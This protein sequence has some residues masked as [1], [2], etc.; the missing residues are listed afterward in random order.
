MWH[1]RVSSAP[2]DRVMVAKIMA[3]SIIWYH[4]PLSTCWDPA[5]DT[6]E[7][8]IQ[9]FIWRD[10]PAKVAKAT[11]RGE[12]NQ[13]GLRVWDIQAK[14]KAFRSMWILKLL[15]GNLNPIL[16]AT[17]KAITE[18]YAHK[19]NTH[20]PLWES[21]VDHS[22]NINAQINSP[23]L[24]AFQQAWTT[25]V[26]RNP[27]LH[28]G[29]WV[30]YANSEEPGKSTADKVYDGR[31]LIVEVDNNQNSST[32]FDRDP[33]MGLF[34]KD[35]LEDNKYW[36]MSNKKCYKLEFPATDLSPNRITETNQKSLYIN[37]GPPRD[38]AELIKLTLEDI[39]A[40]EDEPMPGEKFGPAFL[41]KVDNSRL[42]TAQL[43]RK[44]NFYIKENKWA[45]KYN[46]NI[47]KPRNEQNRSIA[48]SR[49]KGFMW[50][51]YSHAL[52][53]KDRLHGSGS[54][55]CPLCGGKETIKHMAASCE[56]AKATRKLVY[57]EWHGRTGDATS[58][59][60]RNSFFSP[61]QKTLRGDLLITIN[62]ITTQ[63][64]W[65]HRCDAE[66]SRAKPML[67]EILSNNIWTEMDNTISARIKHLET[68]ADWWLTRKE[69]NLVQT[70][71]ADQTIADIA[72][73]RTTLAAYLLEWNRPRALAREAALIHQEWTMHALAD[74]E[75]FIRFRVP[76]PTDLSLTDWG[77]RLSTTPKP[78]KGSLESSTAT[79]TSDWEQE[80]SLSSASEG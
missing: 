74:D 32:W 8:K 72:K 60:F 19:A 43:F 25:I 78:G 26:R 80:Q 45:L 23:L 61:T 35:S 21:R 54:K 15:T 51:F 10:S 77:W 4:A 28:A 13:G 22:E 11:L 34:S 30:A 37:I 44:H 41:K 48:H 20:I 71:L 47:N 75:N 59:K 18:L 66:Y 39:L 42:Y 9:T 50:L 7:K 63:Q 16:T 56:I 69:A 33:D 67:P 17:F 68:R 24:A 73:E 76:P 52:P 79:E 3:L 12:K 2:K 38:G 55:D 40:Q 31:A 70:E 65:R 36:H 1:N 49:V 53:V 62:G 58:T 29:D 27:T 64:L 14:I 46:I 57:K 6:V 5:L